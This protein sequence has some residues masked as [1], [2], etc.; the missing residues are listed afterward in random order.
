VLT[1]QKKLAGPSIQVKL[2]YQKVNGSLQLVV[3][4]YIPPMWIG[5]MSGSF[6]A[7]KHT[8]LL[9]SS[10]NLRRDFLG[11]VLVGV[12]SGVILITGAGVA[13]RNSFE[14]VLKDVLEEVLGQVLEDA[15]MLGHTCC[16]G[17]WPYGDDI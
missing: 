3:G 15:I 5:F 14:S 12:L 6:S 17:N 16:G 1:T 9:S 10:V 13:G 2:G 8:C 11:L 7:S 4:P